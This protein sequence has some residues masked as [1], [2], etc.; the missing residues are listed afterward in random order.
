MHPMRRLC[1]TYFLFVVSTS[2]FS[3]SVHRAKREGAA[4]RTR[5]HPLDKS[6]FAAV[7]YVSLHLEHLQPS[8][9]AACADDDLHTVARVNELKL[10]ETGGIVLATAHLQSARTRL[11]LS[12]RR[13][14]VGIG[15]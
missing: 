1:G 3:I 10:D 11:D 7:G 12:D 8:E 9:H 13:R 14:Q 6:V 2:A 5:R 15:T 4:T